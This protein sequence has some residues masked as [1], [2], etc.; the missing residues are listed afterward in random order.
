[1][2]T[3]KEL[4]DVDTMKVWGITTEN[5][6]EGRSTKTVGI[7]KG[8]L[9]DIAEY[10]AQRDIKPYYNFYARELVVTGV[11]SLVTTTH[12]VETVDCCETTGKLKIINK[13]SLLDCEVCGSKATV[14]VIGTTPY[15]FKQCNHCGC[16]FIDAEIERLNKI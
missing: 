16:G 9:L 11:K 8:E 14:A 4:L 12:K 1:M 13:T 15:L 7:F 6:C 5:D 2:E 3:E 10:L